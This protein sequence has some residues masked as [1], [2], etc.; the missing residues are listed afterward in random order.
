MSFP[1]DDIRVLVP[2]PQALAVI[3][4]PHACNFID[5]DLAIIASV[6]RQSIME[7]VEIVM[8]SACLMPKTI[9]AENWVPEVGSGLPS[10]RCK[11]NEASRC[12]QTGKPPQPTRKCPLRQMR[13]K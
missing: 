6:D 8:L 7:R 2:K 10:V 5:A 3:D 9:R 1:L 11:E 4:E 12:S 13:E